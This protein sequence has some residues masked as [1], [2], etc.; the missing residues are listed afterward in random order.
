MVEQP[1]KEVVGGHAPKKQYLST[2]N[3]M[4]EADCIYQK[5]V[6]RQ[7]DLIVTSLWLHHALPYLLITMVDDLVTHSPG[8]VHAHFLGVMR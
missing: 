2:Y 6:Q 7:A 8:Q 3:N 1:P 4:T 5:I